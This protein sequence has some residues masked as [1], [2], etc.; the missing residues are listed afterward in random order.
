MLC[1]LGQ[2]TWYCWASVLAFASSGDNAV[3]ALPTSPH[4]HFTIPDTRTRTFLRL[5]IYWKVLVT[6]FGGLPLDFGASC[7]TLPY[8]T[9]RDFV[10]P[11]AGPLAFIRGQADPAAWKISCL[12]FRM[13][14]FWNYGISRAPQTTAGMVPE[15]S[16]LLDVSPSLSF[17]S[18]FL[19]NCLRE[20]T[21]QSHLHTNSSQDLLLQN[22]TKLM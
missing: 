10:C 13:N 18:H 11:P 19:T 14:T 20:C 15:V 8:R 6:F 1:D 7:F 16:D 12:A 22:P 4:M 17:F 2:A 5:S 9:A 3:G 21:P